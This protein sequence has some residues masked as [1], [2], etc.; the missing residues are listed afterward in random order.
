MAANLRYLEDEWQILNIASKNYLL[1]DLL[2]SEPVTQQLV[3]ALRL[4]SLSPNQVL[5]EQGDRIDHLYFPLNCVVSVLGIMEDGT[6]V[7]TAMVGREGLVD[8]SAILGS[9]ASRQWTWV[10]I[11]G[12]ALQL[13][14]KVLDDLFVSSEVAMKALLRCYRSLMIQI[15][16]RCICN[17]RHTIQ[18]RLCC[19]LLM[20]HDRV[21]GQNLR[22]TQETIASRVG[23]RRAGITVAAGMLQAAGAIEYR[24]GHLHIT[25]RALLEEIVCE[26]YTLLKTDLDGRAPPP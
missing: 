2:S 6:T 25:D 1:R 9:G 15:S 12:D 3:P 26:C 18:E 16:Q 7:E 20:L 10:A 4:L 24:R 11:R 14:A 8:I 23:A 22:L 13:E 17:T 5:Y 19:W 21:G